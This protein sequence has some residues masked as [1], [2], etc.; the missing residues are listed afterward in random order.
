M[1]SNIG[2]AELNPP[3][4]LIMGPG[5]LMADPRVL[6]SMATPM[7]GQFDPAFL[8]IMARVQQF[9]REIYRTGNKQ[10]LMIDG[11]ARAGIEAILVSLIEPGDKVLVPMFG[12]FGHLLV[13]I[14][15]RCG[16]DVVT[17]E[18]PWG[19]V[20]TP[21]EIEKA[22]KQHQ[23]KII[24]L[25][26]ADTSTTVAQPLEDIGALCRAH[27]AYLYV[28]ACAS[29]G[30][31]DIR[32][33]EWQ[34]DGISAGLQK[35]LSGPPGMSPVTVSE[36]AVARIR[37]RRHVEA[38]VRPANY[39]AGQGPRIRS[40]YFD[41]SMLMDYWGDD[42][43]NHHTEATSMIYA[44]HECGR[45]F[46]DE[47][48]EAVFARHRVVGDALCDGLEAMGLKVF[49]DRAAKMPN[50][51][52]V[53]IPEGV[54]GDAVRKGMLAHFGIEIGTSFGPLHGKIWRIGTMGYTARKENVLIC[55]GALEAMLLA[56][57][58]KLPA[59]AAVQ[60]AMKA[61]GEAGV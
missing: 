1:A 44:A 32:A 27:G 26:H 40:N 18:R 7:L 45:I 59:G 52:G 13:E 56:V 28:D 9:F 31:I 33:D 47:G 15:E 41:L 51:T 50:V 25:V 57:G 38:G 10:T 23:P 37:N 55:L 43:L 29:I 35:G 58:F 53:H 22:L 14:C 5:P 19:E 24:A 34:I 17:I 61:F 39:V 36:R 54:D 42:H 8:D 4:R 6:R 12:R 49:G 30:C 48:H 16:G 60:A 11:S 3:P 2:A 21:D 46:L 20:F